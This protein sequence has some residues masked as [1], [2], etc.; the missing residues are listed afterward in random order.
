M[1]IVFFVDFFTATEASICFSDDQ[2]LYKLRWR[3]RA[4]S[5]AKRLVNSNCDDYGGGISISSISS[6]SY[7]SS[8]DSFTSKIYIDLY[9]ASS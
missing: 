6:S 3:E 4:E 8:S 9:S 1:L 7:C 5:F 2:E